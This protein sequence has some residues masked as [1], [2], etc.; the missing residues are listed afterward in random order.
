M[1]KDGSTHPDAD[2]VFDVRRGRTAKISNEPPVTFI[3]PDF[4]KI[5]EIFSFSLT[6]SFMKTQVSSIKM[7]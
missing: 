5:Y 4:V 6:K 3:V 1:L 7:F 2:E